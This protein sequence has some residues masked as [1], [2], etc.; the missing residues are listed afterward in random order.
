[1]LKS[2][3]FNYVSI[4]VLTTLLVGGIYHYNDIIVGICTMF[5]L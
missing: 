1:M 4:A 3:L 2:N 5:R